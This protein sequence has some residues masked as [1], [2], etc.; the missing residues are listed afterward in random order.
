MVAA[1]TLLGTLLT[2][3]SHEVTPPELGV[4]GRGRV[5]HGPREDDRAGKSVRFVFRRRS[6]RRGGA[7]AQWQSSGLLTHWFRVRPP[8]APPGKTLGSDSQAWHGSWHGYAHPRYRVV[9]A[10]ARS[11][12]IQQ[13]PSGAFRVS[14]YAGTDPLTGRQI[15]L[16]QTCKTERA[17]QI[18]LGRLLEQAAAG[19]QPETDATVA[20]LMDRYAE[21]ADWDLSTRKA[22]EYYIRRVI[23]P[24]LGHLQVRKIRGP[25]LDLLYAQLKRCGDLACKGKPFVEHR[26]VPML[27]VDSTSR[28]PAWQQVV[29]TIQTAI[30]S[31]MLAVG[32]PLPSVRELSAL[33]GVPTA[34]LQHALTVLA[35]EG[36]VLVRQGRTAIVAGQA[37]SKGPPGRAP[38]PR[39]HDC[40]R[41]GCKP[42]VCKP[43]AAKTIRNMHSIL[44]GAFATAKRWE[45]IAW[46]PAESARPPAASRR[47]LPATAPGDVAKVIAEGRKANPE[48]AL[49]LWLVAITGARRGELCALQVCDIDLD[50][51]ILHIGFSYVVVGGRQVRK[52][53]K[54]HQDRYLA[55]DP[56]TCGILREHLDTARAK[57]ADFG[58]ELPKDAYVF[59][60]DPMNAKPWNPDWA[61]H[62]TSA[63]AA[64]AGVKLNIK[65]LRHYTAS[66]LLAAR[67]DLRNTAA[68]LGHGSGGATTL[69]HYADPVSEVDRRAAAYLAQLT[70]GSAAS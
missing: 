34:T 19:G 21:V 17:A 31:G 46:N 2:D 25:L 67:F 20:Q 12:Y 53:T 15:R 33:Q 27:V 50:N 70:A 40:K 52:D 54:T 32:E 37:D 8:G 35:D 45:W 49:Y 11:G 44:S 61:T 36:L 56:V 30:R 18:E 6:V 55:I 5:R 1:T 64:T 65:E 26:N 59:S 63:L 39:D 57:L 22:N 10:K 29:D 38:R 13:L 14:V 28:Q 16:R 60:N 23:K 68:R 9:M 58:L 51:G 4:T 7:L 41:A 43:M 3:S 47:P 62:K 69:R 48:M 66:Q 42:H 24:A